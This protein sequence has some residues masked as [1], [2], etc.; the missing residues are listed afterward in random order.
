MKPG[1]HMEKTAR[2]TSEVERSIRKNNRLSLVMILTIAV[3]AVVSIYL[4]TVVS[5]QIMWGLVL[6]IL[7]LAVFFYLSGR[8][9]T[10]KYLLQI[11]MD[12][13]SLLPAKER[14][15]KA[16]RRLFDYLFETDSGQHYIDEQTWKDLNMDR[17]YGRID[18]AYTDPGEAVLYRILREP[19][20]DRE[21]LAGR[22]R[23]VRFLLENP[24]AREKIQLCL[25]R[26]GHQY[27]RNE[28]FTLLWEKEFVKSRLRPVFT[29]MALA[30]VVSIIIPFVFWSGILVL[31]PVAVFI[32]NIL[33]HYQ[34]KH[35]KDLETMSFP[36]L[37]GCIKAAGRLSSL[38]YEETGRYSGKLE[39]LYRACRGILKKARFLFPVN[40]AFADPAQIVY[41]Y[42]NIFFLLEIRAFYATTEELARCLPELR[43]IYL[44]LGELDA[45]QSVAS[46]R[47]GLTG[48]SEP[49]FAGE[50]IHLE[51]KDAVQP[52]LDSPVPATISIIKN[53]VII[54]GSNMGG[55][56][57]FLRTIGNNVLLAQTIATPIASH[58]R[59]TFFRIVTSISR[60]DDLIAGKSFYYVEAER[61]LKTIQSFGEGIPTLCIID[62]LLSGTNS[63]ERL[64]ASEAIIRYLATKNT[65]AIIATHDLELA[66]R[67]NGVCEFYH[68][69]GNV[70]EN[71][72]KFDYLLKP[73]IATTRNAIALL[74]YLG[75]PREITE[76]SDKPGN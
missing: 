47:A 1:K 5:S 56:S 49:E 64:Q 45:L 34:V 66:E 30:A 57:T 3:I 50:G 58:Y 6:V 54:T 76:R 8:R 19:L 20:F 73:G 38:A 67:L 52:L 36:Y 72:L 37:I 41:E 61:I 46:Y 16:A 29:F 13:G 75:Y 53:V 22:R 51:V 40:Q 62:E 74:R 39:E 32:A 59:G 17:L 4:G 15:M 25:I 31:V 43:E 42:F 35:G 44:T 68:F 60:T 11:R 18:R 27:A 63:I 70:D 10:L 21:E 71:G 48:W 14:D 24:E 9:R 55:K 28:L 12:W 33:V 2:N 26:F 69:T 23:V 65:L 7:I